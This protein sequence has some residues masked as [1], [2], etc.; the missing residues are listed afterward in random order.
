M[1]RKTDRNLQEMNLEK[2]MILRKKYKT[3]LE[4]VRNLKKQNQERI[5]KKV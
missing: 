4:K 1:K 5:Q 3:K 2:V